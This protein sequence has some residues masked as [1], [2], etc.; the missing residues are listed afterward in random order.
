MAEEG[1]GRHNDFGRV[2]SDFVKV[3]TKNPKKTSF[4]VCKAIEVILCITAICLTNNP[5]DDYRIRRDFL[6]SFT[7]IE[8]AIVFTSLY[9]FTLTNLIFVLSSVL[10]DKLPKKMLMLFSG[11]ASSL[12]CIAGVILIIELDE[13]TIMPQEIQLLPSG[14]FTIL[15]SVTF[16]LE[17]L[18][19]YKYA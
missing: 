16:A 5:L 1:D 10:G 8:G 4:F 9:G 19:T 2:K 12:C 18:L 3:V 11:V 14:I 6:N 17:T 13:N 7:D 15:A